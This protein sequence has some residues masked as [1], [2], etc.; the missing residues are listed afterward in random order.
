MS[1]IL[2]FNFLKLT[3]TMMAKVM[4]EINYILTVK[5]YLGIKYIWNYLKPKI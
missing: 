3:Y 4:I 5:K 2:N 1:K